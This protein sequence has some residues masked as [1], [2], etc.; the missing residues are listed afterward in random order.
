M[1][2][3]RKNFI[4]ITSPFINSAINFRKIKLS[5]YIRLGILECCHLN[6][7]K[8]L[9]QPFHKHSIFMDGASSLHSFPFL[10]RP[11]HWRMVIR[12]CMFNLESIKS[13]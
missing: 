10:H 13:P 2:N 12:E 1:E 11:L 9:L 4:M 7:I 6:V 5:L 3:V 8:F